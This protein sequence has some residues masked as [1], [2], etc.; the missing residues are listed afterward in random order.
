V[1]ERD[2]DTFTLNLAAVGDERSDACSSYV[3][4]KEKRL[5]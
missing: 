1:E 3:T 5:Y 4:S 2:I